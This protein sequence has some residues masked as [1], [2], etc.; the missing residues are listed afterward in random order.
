MLNKIKEW[1]IS[2]DPEFSFAYAVTVFLATVYL[3]TWSLNYILAEFLN[4]TGLWFIL[5]CWIIWSF[6]N[7]IIM[8]WKNKNIEEKEEEEDEPQFL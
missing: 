1:Y 2:K 7:V 3:V 4:F 5:L 8:F 6:G